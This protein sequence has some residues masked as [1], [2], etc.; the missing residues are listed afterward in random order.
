MKTIII[1]IFAIFYSNAFSQ[2]IINT[3]GTGGNFIV[4][5]G[6][7]D[8]LV[9]HQSSG[10]LNLFNSVTL[11]NT[12]GP[13]VGVIYKGSDR[14]IHDYGYGNIFLGIQSGNFTMTGSFNSGIGEVSLTANTSGE[15]N[16]AFGYYTLGYNTTGYSNTAI[17]CESLLEN[18]DGF[19][20]T[21]V[22]TQ[23]LVVNK[24][25]SHN[26]SVGAFSMYENTNGH[27]N[28][29]V[30][31]NAIYN[32]LIGADNT[33]VGYNS[34][35]DNTLGSHNTSVG[36]NSLSDN[37]IGFYN[38]AIGYSSGSTILTGVNLTCIGTDAQ[39]TSSSAVNQITLGNN[40]IT[41]LRCNTQTITSLSDI[42][43]K[44]N[45]KD[46][47]LGLDFIMKIKPRMFNWDKRE[48]YDDNKSDGSKMSGTPTAGFIAQELDE[49]QTNEHADWLNL[50]LKDNP[51][52]IEAT[53]GNLLPVMV[54]AIQDLKT[55]KDEL[56]SEV[57]QLKAANGN[58]ASEVEALKI[59]NDRIAKLEKM[60]DE[61]NSVKHASNL[62]QEE[63]NLT[64]NK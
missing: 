7:N 22:G 17:G 27:N 10:Q 40:R 58:L 37:T 19:N 26:T 59:S 61:M 5:D 47:P 14:F 38:T 43:D 32:N 12:T 54:K 31:E 42:R 28:T 41:T 21:G 50:V 4:K 60:M 52:K 15:G 23:A 46:L 9:L 35:Y 45:I 51:D 55:E 24:S 6:S 62:K 13:S 63:V 1:V 34:M 3:L 49:A 36:R 30:G 48:W 64:N 18:V 11:E 16:T 56:K 57:E 20:N 39:P 33:A 25:G 29:A 53:Y 8:F 2:D 44:K